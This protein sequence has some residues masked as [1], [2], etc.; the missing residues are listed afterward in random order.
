MLLLYTRF[1]S[2]AQ[3]PSESEKTQLERR[4][5]DQTE[6]DLEEENSIILRQEKPTEKTEN[7]KQ[8]YH[9]ERRFLL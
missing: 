7:L 1:F 9:L 8:L 4:N 5:F 2:C 6:T 3:T